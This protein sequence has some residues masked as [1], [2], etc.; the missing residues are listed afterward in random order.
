VITA[1]FTD[2]D[3]ARAAARDLAA[4]GVAT[5]IGRSEGGFMARFVVI[6]AACSVLGTAAGAAFGAVLSY[7]VGPDGT[8]G[9]ILLVVSWA[10]FAHLLIGLLAGYFLLSARSENEF[11]PGAATTL[12]A[13][14]DTSSAQE[15]AERLRSDGATHVSG[16]DDTTIE[17]VSDRQERKE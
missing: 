10:L 3:A 2:G 1:S 17:V 13:R 12:T 8:E 5:S 9:M 15:I 16:D 14:A 4:A 7:T 6:V 11:A